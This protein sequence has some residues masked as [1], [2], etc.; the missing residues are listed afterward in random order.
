MDLRGVGCDLEIEDTP[1]P[2]FPRPA[3]QTWTGRLPRSASAG[4]NQNHHLRRPGNGRQP[5]F[6]NDD[7]GVSGVLQLRL[8]SWSRSKAVSIANWWRRELERSR[9]SAGGLEAAAGVHD[10]W[11]RLSP[12]EIAEWADSLGGVVQVLKQ[13]DPEDRAALYAELG[14]T[15]RYD[16]TRHQIKATA[17]L[18]CV[19]RGVG[20]GTLNPHALAGTSPSSWR[21]CLFRHSD[22]AADRDRRGPDGASYCTPTPRPRP[23]AAH[24]PLLWHRLAIHLR[25]GGREL[26]DPVLR[27][28]ERAGRGGALADVHDVGPLHKADGR[29]EKRDAW[30]D[31]VSTGRP[32]STTEA[33]GCRC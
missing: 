14:L 32:A 22:V 13:A 3:I 29:L 19:A 20:G 7:E 26:D 31:L 2:A 18:S 30:E 16:P 33:P 21:V 11:R 5:G 27:V 17:E 10:Q 24:G 6:G 25:A 23:L 28:P 15:L 12:R 4:N 1:L 9:P 8:G